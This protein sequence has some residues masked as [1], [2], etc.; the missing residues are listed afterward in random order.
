MAGTISGMTITG[1]VPDFIQDAAQGTCEAQGTN[2][3]SAC[4]ILSVFG[5]TDNISATM[6]VTFSVTV[7]AIPMLRFV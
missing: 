3:N 7:L 6:L 1:S 5:T 2:D 4:A